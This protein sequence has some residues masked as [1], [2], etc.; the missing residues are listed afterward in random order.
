MADFS[1]GKPTLVF[2]SSRKGTGETA[3]HLAREAAKAGASWRGGAASAAGSTFVRDGAQ[4][5]RLAAAAGRLKTAALRECVQMGI[6][7]HHAA[8]EPDERAAIEALF[9]AQ[10][11]P[12]GALRNVVVQPPPLSQPCQASHAPP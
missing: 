1:S 7:F 8:M 5:Q 4:A 3:A 2:C 12:V 6:G 10:D 11:L 9:I